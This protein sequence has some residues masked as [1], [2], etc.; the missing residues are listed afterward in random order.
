MRDDAIVRAGVSEGKRVTYVVHNAIVDRH[1]A[2]TACT[3]VLD[4]LGPRLKRA[5]VDAYTDYRDELPTQAASAERWLFDRGRAR[6]HGDPGMGV[7]LDLS[8]PQ[9]WAIL[10]SYAPWSICVELKDEVGS[11]LGGFDDW[12]TRSAPS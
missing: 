11:E 1:E 12:A 7:D 5:S 3:L 8:D 9:H 2:I 10:R 6:G 4:L